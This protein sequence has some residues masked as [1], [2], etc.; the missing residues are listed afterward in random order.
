ML[1]TM[2]TVEHLD[3]LNAY[4]MELVRKLS[5]SYHRPQEYITIKDTLAQVDAIR[6]DLIAH[7]ELL[8]KPINY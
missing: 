3:K 4:R 5:S 1:N 7:L 8:Q 2:Q 6:N